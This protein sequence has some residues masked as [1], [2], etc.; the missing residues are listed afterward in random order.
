[1]ANLNPENQDLKFGEWQE[2]EHHIPVKV[3][4]IEVDEGGNLKGVRWEEGER[5]HKERYTYAKLLP[6]QICPQG[7]HYFEIQ[8]NGQRVGG[9]LVVKCRHC[10]VGVHFIVGIHRLE[11]GQILDNRPQHS[12]AQG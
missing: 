10:N 9:R 5:V 8:N 3:P 12:E 2:E 6:H 1:M 7:K 11:N 4:M